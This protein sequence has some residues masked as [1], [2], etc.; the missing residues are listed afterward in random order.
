MMN[1][2][3]MLQNSDAIVR[4]DCCICGA[5]TRLFGIEPEAPDFELLSFECDACQHI[6]TRHE[7]VRAEL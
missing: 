3:Q 2:H 6:E 5:Q 1:Y 7:K 4:P